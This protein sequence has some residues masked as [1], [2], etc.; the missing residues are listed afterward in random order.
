MKAIIQAI[1]THLQGI[2]DVNN[3]PILKRIDLYNNQFD[4]YEK[5][6]PL[7]LPAV[8]VEIMPI[9]WARVKRGVQMGKVNIRFHLG[10]ELYSDSFQG[11]PSQSRALEVLDLVQKLYLALQNYQI[12]DCSP[13]ERVQTTTDTQY[14][15]CI[16]HILEYT[17]EY[18]DSTKAIQEDS[19]YVKVT[20]DLEPHIEE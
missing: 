19:Q 16:V 14:G 13:M 5:D 8:L 18:N 15:N 12:P 7:P 20:P 9:A 17:F 1:F 10:Q 4:T 6:H 2:I 3:Q 11:S